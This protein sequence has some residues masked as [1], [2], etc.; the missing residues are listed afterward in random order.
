DPS[1]PDIPK[2]RRGLS[3]EELYSNLFVINFAGHD[4]TANTIAFAIFSLAANPAVQEWVSEE[5]EAVVGDLEPEEW[6][7]DDL[8][9]KLNRCRAV[10]WE[11]LR[12]FPP[13]MGIPK[14]TANKP[15]Q[16][17]VQGQVLNLPAE[18][19]TYIYPMALHTMPQYWEDPLAWKPSR[20]VVVSAEGGLANETFF[21]PRPGTFLPWSAGAQNCPGKKFA[22]VEAAA[23]VLRLLHRHHI[24][25]KLEP[26]E[27][28][29]SGFARAKA[30]MDD[31]DCSLVLRMV[32]PLNTKLIY[33]P[34]G[35]N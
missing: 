1:L 27:S 14:W 6:K 21:E 22:D 29:E 15:Q 26:G 25:V 28:E 8:F 31:V 32:D 10:F 11:S 18:T 4:T 23:L 33:E 30:C 13:V 3:L 5:I 17:S 9:P 16:L 34:H 7:Y 20:W 12:L 19:R 2:N 35:R 24:K